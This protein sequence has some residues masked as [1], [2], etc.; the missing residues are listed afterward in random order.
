MWVDAD[1]RKDAL[2]REN[3]REGPFFKVKNDPRVTRIGR[4]LRKYSL[5]ELPQLWNVLRGDMSLVGPRLHPVDDFE[6]FSV[7]DLR[8]LEV[9][10]GMTGLWQISG[11][12]DPSFETNLALDLEYI[13]NWSAWLDLQ[14]LFRTIPEALKG[15]G[16]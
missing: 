1:S 11:R 2:R 3:S 5:D 16:E 15:K 13:E 8:R 7:E 10:P 9:K 4:W 12:Q 14:I 6:R